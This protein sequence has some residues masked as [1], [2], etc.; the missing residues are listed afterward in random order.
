LMVS[1]DKAVAVSSVDDK[2]YASTYTH[3]GSRGCVAF[4]NACAVVLDS[5]HTL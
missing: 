2:P 4:K 5:Q 1:G 3:I